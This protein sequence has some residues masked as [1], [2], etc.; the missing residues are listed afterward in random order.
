L[1]E[2]ERERVYGSEGE[3]NFDRETV[4]DGETVTE[5]WGTIRAKGY[6]ST[7]DGTRHNAHQV[8]P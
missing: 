8:R 3:R 1:R 5:E 4:T 6:G 2:R 7:Q